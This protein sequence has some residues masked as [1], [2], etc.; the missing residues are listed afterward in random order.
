MERGHVDS[1][2]SARLLREEHDTCLNRLWP[3]LYTGALD[4]VV[5]R[6]FGKGDAKVKGRMHARQNVGYNLHLMYA[7][8]LRQVKDTVNFGQVVNSG[9]AYH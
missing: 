4:N 7:L 2:P 9:K 6:R 1:R 5:R 3:P 8:H